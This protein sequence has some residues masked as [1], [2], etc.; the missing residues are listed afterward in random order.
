MSHY[1]AIYTVADDGSGVEERESAMLVLNEAD[2]AQA[3]SAVLSYSPEFQNAEVLKAYTLKRDGRRIDVPKSGYHVGNIGS[4]DQMGRTVLTV[5]FP[6]LAVGDTAVYAFRVTAKEPIFPRQFSLDKR[7]QVAEAYDDVKIKIDAPIALW[8]SYKANELREVHKVEKGGRRVIEWAWDN[9]EPRA[10]K[11]TNFSVYDDEQ[12]PGLAFSTFTRHVDI[13]KAY[14]ERAKPK[15]LVSVR[16][17]TLADEIAKGK[18][19]PRDVARALYD[20]VVLN[21]GVEG[22]GIVLGSVVP[23]DLDTTLDKRVG[24]AKDHAALLQALLSAK[25][26]RSTQALL[27]GDSS[28]VV[29]QVPV[30]ARMNHVINYIPS[31]KLFLDSTAQAT[32]FGMLPFSVEDK[33]VFLVDGHQEGLKT[34]IQPV[35]ANQQTMTTKVRIYEDGSAKGEVQVRLTGMHAVNSRI[36]MRN[37]SVDQEPVLVQTYFRG[38]GYAGDGSFSRDELTVLDDA[39]GYSAKFEVKGMFPKIGAGAFIVQ[40]MFFSESPVADYLEAAT[41][42]VE[43]HAHVTCSSSRSVE[44]YTYELPARMTVVSLPKDVNIKSEFLSYSASYQLKGRTLTVKRVF[45]DRSKGNVCS[46]AVA[47]AYQQFAQQAAPDAKAQVVIK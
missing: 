25:G 10:N 8:G 22:E 16:V 41:L 38:G 29:S 28:Y 23:R 3:S 19:A 18:T 43:E 40:P 2:L 11:R 33:P 26:I 6:E 32:P 1:S 44:K 9:K 13:A 21:I 20:W 39:F 5:A 17:K 47:K 46:P 27:N 34:P 37:I 4:A 15:A 42:P 30:V 24:D 12:E 45:D 7:F 36:K 31:L 35:G 14:G